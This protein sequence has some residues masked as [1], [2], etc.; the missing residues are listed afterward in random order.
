MNSHKSAHTKS[1]KSTKS[2]KWLK[3][4]WAKAQKRK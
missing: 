4:S 3:Y 1:T 2:T